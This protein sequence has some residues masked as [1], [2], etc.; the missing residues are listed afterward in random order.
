MEE[1]KGRRYPAFFNPFQQI[2]SIRFFNIDGAHVDASIAFDA[3]VE[4][5]LPER[6]SFL[7]SHP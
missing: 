6:F 7:L 1:R 3:F 2:Q 4:L 5:V